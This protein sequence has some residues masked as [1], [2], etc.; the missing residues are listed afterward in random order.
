MLLREIRNEKGLTISALSE[1][2]EI[3]TKRLKIIERGLDKPSEKE[4]ETIGEYFDLTEIDLK[5]IIKSTNK[6]G[7]VIGEGYV[8]DILSAPTDNNLSPI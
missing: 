1:A 7:K 2:T 4:L 5:K 8:C 6:K 3:Q